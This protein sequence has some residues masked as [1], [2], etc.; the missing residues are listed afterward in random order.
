LSALTVLIQLKRWDYFDA[1]KG[2]PGCRV[3]IV[4]AMVRKREINAC[5]M[6]QMVCESRK[7]P[8]AKL[9]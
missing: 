3:A 2:A 1:G 7:G 9:T 5:L 6:I 4:S 8:S